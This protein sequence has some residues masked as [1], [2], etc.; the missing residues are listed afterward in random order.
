MKNTLKS[1]IQNRQQG[2]TII[3]LLIATAILSTILVTVSVRMINISNLYYKG[4][5]QCRSQDDVRNISEDIASKL[6]LTEGNLTPALTKVG[7]NIQSGAYCVGHTKY[8]FVIGKQI[9]KSPSASQSKQ[10]LWKSKIDT[11]GVCTPLNL[12]TTTPTDGGTE[13]IGPNSRLVDFRLEGKPPDNS[14]PYTLYIKVAYGDDDLLC[15]PK[16]VSP[17]TC[18]IENTMSSAYFINGDLQ[19]K[20]TKGRQF[21]GVAKLNTTII[22]RVTGTTD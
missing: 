20:G 19:C 1:P 13:L 3:E 14:S 8:S 4:T 6:R 15:S 17:D 9:S 2:F 11:P 21:C 12:S 10:V 16:V 22:R 5:N 18:N 7:T